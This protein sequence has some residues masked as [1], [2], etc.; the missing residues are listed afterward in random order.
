METNELIKKHLSIDQNYINEIKRENALNEED[1]FNLLKWWL[2]LTK[3][4]TI[5]DLSIHSKNTPLIFLKKDSNL[6]Y[7]NAD[8]NKEGV[9]EFLVNK[10][11]SF[12]TIPNVKG[13]LNKITNRSDSEPIKGFYLYKEI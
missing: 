9:S 10:V 5:G 13:I 3:K 4:T 11:N 2:K 12:T 6:Y 8:T 7:L 1:F